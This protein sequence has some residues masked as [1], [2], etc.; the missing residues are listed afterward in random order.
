MSYYLVVFIRKINSLCFTPKVFLSNSYRTKGGSFV[1][2]YS[3]R[4]SHH[5]YSLKKDVLKNFAKFLRTPF[6]QNTS[7]QLFL[8]FIK[9]RWFINRSAKD[10]YVLHKSSFQIYQLNFLNEKLV[11]VFAYIL[12]S[13][14]TNEKMGSSN[15]GIYPNVL[16]FQDEGYKIRRI[17]KYFSKETKK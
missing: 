9:F 7:K 12:N 6:L 13:S 11:E 16:F 15:Q 8:S 3:V 5:R 4:S 2:I 1:C 14:K 10:W 17:I